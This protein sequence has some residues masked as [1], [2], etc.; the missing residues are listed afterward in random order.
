MNLNKTE[1]AELINESYPTLQVNSSSLQI[2]VY[3]VTVYEQ[4]LIGSN[5]PQNI[6]SLYFGTLQ[7]QFNKDSSFGLKVNTSI[8]SKNRSHFLDINTRSARTTNDVFVKY[9][10]LLISYLSCIDENMKSG[11]SFYGYKINW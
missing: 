11:I 8:G 5:Q 7:Y 1:L 9:E 3:G 10:N 2:A 6:K 4:L